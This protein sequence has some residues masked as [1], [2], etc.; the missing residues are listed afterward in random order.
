MLPVL[1]RELRTAAQERVRRRRTV[2]AVGYASLVLAGILVAERW[3]GRVMLQSATA[4]L[5]VWA[6]TGLIPVLALVGGINRVGQ[7]I[8]TEHREGT[9]PLLLLARLTGFE[10]VMG[11]VFQALLLQ[12]T[13]FLV[14]LPVLV[15]PVLAAGWP[16][17]QVWRIALALLNTLFFGLA[18]GALTS[19][20]ARGERGWRFFLVLPFV[21]DAMPV[22]LLMPSQVRLALGWLDWVNPCQALGHAQSAAAG[23][24]PSAFWASLL[25]SHA[26]AWVF[27]G[28]GGWLLSRMTLWRG[29]MDTLP[30]GGKRMRGL[31]RG[32]GPSSSARRERLRKGNPYLWLATRDWWKA[33][34]P[35]LLLAFPA[36]FWA[37]ATWTM[38]GRGVNLAYVMAVANGVSWLFTLLVL[39]PVEAAKQLANDRASCALEMLVC[40]PLSLRGMVHGQWLALRRR[41]LGP[42]LVATLISA[43]LMIAGY[44]T[45]GFGGMLDSAERLLWLF[46]W[47][48]GIL[49][50]PSVG[51]ALGWIA[52]SRAVTAANPEQAG[53]MTFLYGAMG[54]AILLGFLFSSAWAGVG[55]ASL[56]LVVY[57]GTLGILAWQARTTLLGRPEAIGPSC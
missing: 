16:W 31:F 29:S 57:M 53:I 7:M 26:L 51:T 45:F 24:R 30:S 37:W 17:A 34:T 12:V 39:I 23:V 28:L 36:V 21:A 3:T 8:G 14:L 50:L 55:T 5:L 44:A 6:V 2:L 20:L 42:V 15:L 32:W 56:F 41:Y 13:G 38:A 35:W 10:I 46:W 33:F 1:T 47:S 11:K 9:L 27:L 43:V 19:V 52:M 40:T 54:P 48:S 25:G 22:S 4:G 49:L 18:L